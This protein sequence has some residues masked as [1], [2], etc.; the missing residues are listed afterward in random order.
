[1]KAIIQ[2]VSNAS[3]TVDGEVRGSID[4]GFLILLGVEDGDDE[5]EA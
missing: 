1:M 3:V 5:R 4:K 2:R